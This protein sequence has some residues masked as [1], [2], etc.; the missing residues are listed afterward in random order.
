MIR[1]AILQK[2]G[3]FT[4]PEGCTP[5]NTAAIASDL[6]GK[7]FGLECKEEGIEDDDSNFTRFLLLGR[8]G[9]VQHLNKKIPSK[10]SLVFTLPNSAGALYKALACFSLRDVDMSKIESRPMSAGLL[11]YLRF[12]NTVTQLGGARTG[13]TLPTSQELPRFRYCFYLDILESE[14]DERVQNALHHL[15]EQSDYCRILGSYPAKSRLVGPV[16]EAVEALNAANAG[17]S[18]S[19]EDLRMKSLPSDEED[20]RQ[21][22]IGFIGY[23]SF[24]Q[25]LSKNMPAQHKL[26]CID[27]LDKVSTSFVHY[28]HKVSHALNLSFCNVDERSGRKQC[29]LLSYV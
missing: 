20:A 3:K 6:A 17:K 18:T 24:G 26:R 9:V 29:R 8:R 1:N 22:N 16:A 5:E 7:T 21:L 25:Y 14:L 13:S 4:L 10:T 23:G 2:E 12:R 15:R 11:N 19:S 28:L 27:P